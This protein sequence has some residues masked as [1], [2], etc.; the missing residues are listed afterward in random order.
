MKLP[1]RK[2]T[3]LKCYEYS[4]SGVY[5][6]TIYTQDRRCILSEIVGEGQAPPLQF[7]W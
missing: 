5:F 1:Q 6:I 4:A 3:R 7:R 2:P